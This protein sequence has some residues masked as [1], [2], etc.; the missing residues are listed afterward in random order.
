MVANNHIAVAARTGSVEVRNAAGLLLAKLDAG[1]ALAFDPQ[2]G[3]STA[4]K[5]TGRIL[6][7]N[8]KY[9]LTDKTTNVTVELQGSNLDRYIGKSVT[10]TGSISP[11]MVAAGA[12]QVVQVTDVSLAPAAAGTGAVAGGSAAGLSTG[13]TAAIIGGVAVGGTVAGLAA[14]GTFSGSSASRQ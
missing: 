13:A 10:V 7:R 3:A 11:N 5:M 4:A 9:F 12:A 6:K 14:A 1:T 8:G 2:A